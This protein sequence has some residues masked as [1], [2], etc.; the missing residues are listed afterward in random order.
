[1]EGPSHLLSSGVVTFAAHWPPNGSSDSCHCWLAS[2]WPSA[3]R[4][5]LC[6]TLFLPQHI[7]PCHL[8]ANSDFFPVEELCTPQ[9]WPPNHLRAVLTALGHP[10]TLQTACTQLEHSQEGVLERLKHCNMTTCKKYAYCGPLDRLVGPI[11]LYLVGNLQQD[12]N[13][14]MGFPQDVL[15]APFSLASGCAGCPLQLSLG[16]AILDAQVTQQLAKPCSLSPWVAKGSP[17]GPLFAV[18]LHLDLVL[19]VKICA[20][21]PPLLH[22]MSGS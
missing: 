21:W 5:L 11:H 19:A 8:T 13:N 20:L 17:S 12:W 16:P 6:L 4:F 15:D 9:E 7:A 14:H 1:M 22:Y 18:L 2:S 3:H 10:V